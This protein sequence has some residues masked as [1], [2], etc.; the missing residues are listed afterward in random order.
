MDGH[1][2][3]LIGINSPE[4]LKSLPDEKMEQLAEELRHFLIKNVNKNGGHLASNLG[5][6]ELSMAIHRVFDAPTDHIIWD[7]GHQSYVH[8]IITGRREAFSSL[9]C[10]DGISGFTRRDESEYD[11]FGAGHSSTSISA[12]L[13]FAEADRIKGSEAYTVAVVGDGAFTGGMIHE[14]LNNCKKDLRL[15][16]IINENEMSIS[17]NIGL[18]AQNLSRLRL[19]PGYFKAKKMTGKILKRIPFIGKWI[20]GVTLKT[21]KAFKNI[22]YGSNYF[23]DLGLYYIGPIDG[24]DYRSVDTALREAKKTGES[25]V[26]HLKTIK[27]KGYA[28]AEDD[29][30]KYHGVVPN[31]IKSE[32]ATLTS[33][34]G[35][36]VCELAE[37]DERVCAVTAAMCDGTGLIRFRD[38]HNDRFFDVGIAEEHAVTF[39]AGLAADGLRPCVAIYSTFLQRAY[40]NIIHDVALQKLPVV[41]CIDRAGLNEKDGPTHHGIFDVAFLSQV[42]NMI[43]YTPVTEE[44]VKRAL[45]AA[46]YSDSPAAVRYSNYHENAEVIEEFYKDGAPGIPS[47]LKNYEDDAELDAVIVTH[48]KIVSE[49]LKARDA[50]QDKGVRLGVILLEYLKP[51]DKLAAEIERLLPKKIK[52]IAYLEEEIRN[53]GM[54]MILSD[55]L[56]KY[57]RIQKIPYTIVATDDDFAVQKEGKTMYESAGV[58]YMDLIKALE[59]LLNEADDDR[60]T[61]AQACL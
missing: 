44:G 23:E 29:P 36:A 1:Y 55:E 13:G 19:R 43:I 28:P 53:G 24:N 31:E 32:D 52:A 5:V 51:Y 4:D 21:K 14:A 30:N 41:L 37:Q 61:T 15:I 57:D 10:P 56:T 54:G 11:S 38:E 26:I 3:Y 7:V 6:V 9:R 48:G 18:F 35:D 22:M 12:A 49:A 59:P 46:I 58:S 60:A 47:A 16:I 27:G 17:K 45:K 20:F 25:A 40:D 42:P 2:K 39:G 34:F 8:K 50:M 33:A